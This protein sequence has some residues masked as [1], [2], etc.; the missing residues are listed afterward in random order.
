MGPD[1]KVSFP[2]VR[3]RNLMKQTATIITKKTLISKRKLAAYGLGIGGCGAMLAG[4]AEAVLIDVTMPFGT[5]LSHSSGF[6]DG[7]NAYGLILTA[8]API[9]SGTTHNAGV[10]QITFGGIN[11]ADSGGFARISIGGA[12]FGSVGYSAA[13]GFYTDPPAS[14]GYTRTPVVF[15]NTSSQ[16][17]GTGAVSPALFASPGNNA[18]FQEKYLIGGE[19]ASITGGVIGFKT[20]DGYWGYL[21]FDWDATAH[22]LTVLSAK[23]E[24]VQGDPA[25]FS[26][27]A[28]P[29]ANPATLMALFSL[30]AVG[31][32]RARRRKAAS[33]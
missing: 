20:G 30:G 5:A 8:G 4:S 33:A 15:P 1:E 26:V 29:E 10:G 11:D 18:F 7:P 6:V 16:T 25:T 13:S 14:Y 2:S 31:L 12:G 3:K 23:V 28:V 17:F 32:G 27:A 24:D 22:T 19:I 9:D 21:E